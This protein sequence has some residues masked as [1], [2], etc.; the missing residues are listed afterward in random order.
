M[1]GKFNDSVEKKSFRALSSSFVDMGFLKGG[2][3]WQLSQWLSSGLVAMVVGAACCLRK[4]VFRATGRPPSCSFDGRYAP[5]STDPHTNDENTCPHN[6][7]SAQYEGR[8]NAE[9][10]NLQLRRP[11]SPASAPRFDVPPEQG[12]WS[13]NVPLVASQRV[14]PGRPM[15]LHLTAQVRRD[16]S[17]KKRRPHS[18]RNSCLLPRG[19]T[20]QESLPHSRRPCKQ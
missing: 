12:S 11:W 14:A 4:A 17:V 19:T 15:G 9:S 1:K 5:R 6:S 2:S 7:E 20:R 13:R 3:R 18:N 16:L 8:R 10:T